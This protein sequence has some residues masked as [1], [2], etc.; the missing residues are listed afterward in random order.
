MRIAWG[1]VSSRRSH[2]PAFANLFQLSEL[3]IDTYRFFVVRA[4]PP[5]RAFGPFRG[6]GLPPDLV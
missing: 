4:S 2:R 6:E 3:V 1:L 5:E